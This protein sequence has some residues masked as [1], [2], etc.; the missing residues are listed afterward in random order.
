MLAEAGLPPKI[1][2]LFKAIL[3]KN[4]IEIDDGVTI[5]ESLDQTNGFAQGENTSPVLFSVLVRKLPSRITS[6]H[7]AVKTIMYADDLVML[8]TSRFHLQ[9][10]A[11]TL[12]NLSREIGLAI[13]EDKTEA[14]K[15]RKGGRLAKHDTLKLNGKEIPFVNKFTY[16]GITFT[17]TGTSFSKHIEDR[18]HKTI[19]AFSTINSPQKLSLDTAIKLFHIKLAPC[20]SY[21]I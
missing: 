18:T 10:A 19:L 15:F 7:P 17:T 20:A 16:L 8:S 6:K 2:N 14:M 1:L 13:N 21:G 5:R 12:N 9:Q 3:Q 4:S 11:S